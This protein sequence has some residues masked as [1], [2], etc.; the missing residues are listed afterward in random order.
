[1]QI[2]RALF[3]VRASQIIRLIERKTSTKAS[4]Q[5]PA[6]KTGH[7]LLV[8]D[9]TPA[10]A[11]KNL[12]QENKYLGAGAVNLKMCIASQEAQAVWSQRSHHK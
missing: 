1:M 5:L 11:T 3:S 6:A 8:R 4:Q 10:A 9:F 2:G 12:M 7:T